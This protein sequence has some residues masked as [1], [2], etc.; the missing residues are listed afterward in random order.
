M[1]RSQ[2]QPTRRSAG[3][4]TS[5][6]APPGSFRGQLTREGRHESSLLWH[7]Y[8]V[9]CRTCRDR[10]SELIKYLLALSAQGKRRMEVLGG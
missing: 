8:V 1:I 3:T 9:G 5:S 7:L 2:L 6:T 10:N 4:T